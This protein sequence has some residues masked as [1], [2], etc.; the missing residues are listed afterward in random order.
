MFGNMLAGMIC[1]EITSAAPEQMLTAVNA[2]Q[3]PLFQVRQTSDLTVSAKIYNKDLVKIKKLTQKRGENLRVLDK[4]GVFWRIISLRKRPV[5]LIGM[6]MYLVLLFFVPTRVFFVQVEGNRSIPD[7]LILEHAGECGIYFGA[8]R[9][10]VRSE[11]V[12]NALL[13]AV[14]QLQWAGVNTNG[15]VAVISVQ[16]RTDVQD[17]AS[18]GVSS[19]VAKRDG[20]ITEVTVTQGSACCRVGQAV[21]AGQML[22]SGYTDCGIAIQATQAKGEIFAQTQY[23]FKV[24]TPTLYEARGTEV[25]S[26]KK[27]QIQLGKKLI[28]LFKGSGISDTRCVKIQ[29]KYN[30]TLPGG[31]VL[32]VSLQVIHVTEYE[33]QSVC[34]EDVETFTWLDNW[35]KEYLC[36]QMV[37]GSILKHET[38]REISDAVCRQRNQFYC[39]ELI[40]Q[41]RNEEIIKGNGQGS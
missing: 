14:P 37:A 10:D 34:I 22:V 17:D 4:E 7:K 15:C 24:I 30:L 26:S 32:P 13:S 23:D 6:L 28:N 21:K 1:I 38:S 12:K 31:F 2:A 40:G 11:R 3:I 39:V 35:S 19:I 41:V 36:G 18:G 27:F 33:N 16:E 29:K 8:S 25:S 9:R 5:L 20:I